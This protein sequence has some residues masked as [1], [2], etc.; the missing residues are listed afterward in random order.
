MLK[1]EKSY[2]FRQ[3]LLQ[4]NPP[5]AL[6]ANVVAAPEEFRVCPGMTLSIPRDSV[7]YTAAKDFGDFMLVSMETPILL[8]TDHPGDITI[9]VDPDYKSYKSYEIT[10][11]GQ[12]VWIKAHDARGAAQALFRLEDR[13]LT[14]HAPF[15]HYGQ[16]TRL[17]LYSPRMTHSGYGLDDF[18]DA[19]LLQIAKAGMDAILV[20]VSDIN[21]TPRGYLDFNNLI[22]RAALHGLDVYAYSYMRVFVHPGDPGAKQRYDDAY[23]RLFRQ[24]PGLKGVVLVGESVGIPTKD[25]KAAP[26]EYY[27]NKI[28]GLPT[29]K[30]SADMWPCM[31]YP[32]WLELLK[33]VILPIR[34]DADIV[35]WTYNWGGQP[36]ED[37]LK[38]IRALPSGISLLVTYEMHHKYKIGNAVGHCADY[39][40]SFPGPG[41][42][43]LS[44]AEAARDKDVRLYAMTNTAGMTWDMGMIPYLPMP[45]QWR[46]RYETME[47]S[48]KELGL[49]GL[50]ESHHYG[51]WPSFVSQCAKEAF[52]SGGEDYDTALRNA[53][54]RCYGDENVAPVDEALKL[55]S[56]A[57]TY[58]IPSNEDQYGAFRVGPAYPFNLGMTAKQA[59]F[60]PSN[61][62]FSIPKYPLD[63]VGKGSLSA[64]RI[65]AEIES[66]DTMLNLM[67]RGQTVLED[68][69]DPNEALEYLINF[70]RFLI[71]CVKT[72]VNAKRW[73]LIVSRLQ[74]AE[75]PE[76]VEQLLEQAYSLLQ[77]EYD[78]VLAA[79][80]CVKL[81]SRLGWE[82]RQE[83][84]CNEDQLLWKLRQIDYVR[85]TELR[86]YQNSI[87]FDLD[88][89]NV[90]ANNFT[91]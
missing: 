58:Y 46:K 63:N 86:S 71:C 39:T 87:Y 38:L 31:D 43:F 64:M 52:E 76:Q 34:P 1:E 80:P 69:S 29:G 50:M 25:P 88:G 36:K 26:C 42:Y 11:T 48:R 13:M 37:R 44:E 90:I 65:H 10:V 40:L 91:L 18:P 85:N 89:S 51:F 17:P 20:F 23:G 56:Q 6:K 30:P 9:T 79:I 78:N 19:H 2:A 4:V 57:I 72:G 59:N 22:H 66:L 7:I 75:E 21:K 61:N 62:D 28:D 83:Y 8:M 41:A 24:C 33:E 27:N 47:T 60:W 16:E 77:E 14:R 49:C 45:Y 3:R 81:D 70:G 32:Q 73:Y 15:L 68:I 67:E 53:L 55:W 5:A 35:F 74:I 82:P 84:R 54:K 12:G